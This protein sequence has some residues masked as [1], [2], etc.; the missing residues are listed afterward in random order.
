MAMGFY[1]IFLRLDI[2]NTIP[3]PD[4]GR[5]HDRRIRGPDLH[6]LHG[7]DPRRSDPGL[8]DRR[9]WPGPHFRLDRYPAQ[10]ERLVHGELTVTVEVNTGD[11]YPEPLLTFPAPAPGRNSWP[12]AGRISGCPAPGY[13]PATGRVRMRSSRTSPPMT[14][15]GCSRWASGLTASSTSRAVARP[16]PAQQRGQ[17]PVRAFQPGLRAAVEFPCRR[18]CSSD[19]ADVG[20]SVRALRPTA[21]QP[22]A[23]MYPPMGARGTFGWRV[24]VLA[25]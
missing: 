13:S 5:L 8:E 15:S 6:G 11:A 24:L 25:S 16:G 2:L 23:M 10:P 1:V 21:G 12:S 20:R 3:G 22:L 9:C 7:G 19:R 4:R 14:V 17:H 18:P